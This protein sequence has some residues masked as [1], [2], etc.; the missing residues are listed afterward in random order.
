MKRKVFL[1]G[2]INLM[3]VFGLV[4]IGC[5]TGTGG[6]SSDNGYNSGNDNGN[7][8]GG[9]NNG[10]NDGN[11][12]GGTG[13]NTPTGVK[14]TLSPSTGFITVEWNPVSGAA[15]YNVYS[16]TNA[17][18]PFSK[19]NTNTITSTSSTGMYWP[20]NIHYFKVTAVNS[21]GEESAFSSYASVPLYFFTLTIRNTSSYSIDAGVYTGNGGLQETVVGINPGSSKTTIALAQGVDYYVRINGISSSTFL[22][23]SSSKTITF[24]GSSFN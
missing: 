10:N 9:N 6:G 17:S 14:A 23:S 1:T 24:N 13:S 11:N 5:D 7:D 2:I 12:G 18:G 4:L 21:Y 15:G 19:S 22:S 20:G 8:Y 16:S 3:L